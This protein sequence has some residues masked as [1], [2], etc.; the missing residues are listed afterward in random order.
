MRFGGSQRYLHQPLVIL[1]IGD[2][3]WTYLTVVRSFLERIWRL[4]LVPVIVS[5][6]R[7]G[8]GKLLTHLHGNVVVDQEGEELRANVAETE[9]L[10]DLGVLSGQTAGD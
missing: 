3:G 6:L 7:L 4:V 8:P 1:T 10:D 5:Q 9:V 2:L